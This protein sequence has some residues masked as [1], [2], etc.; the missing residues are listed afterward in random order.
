LRG[1]RLSVAIFFGARLRRAPKKGLPLQSLLRSTCT[2]FYGAKNTI[3]IHDATD[4]F[5][6]LFF[7]TVVFEQNVDESRPDDSASRF[8]RYLLKIFL[9]FD[10]EADHYRIL[11]VQA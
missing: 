7:P 6:S 8:P 1:G 2:R 10:T 9:V 11:K 3:L 5:G 4:K